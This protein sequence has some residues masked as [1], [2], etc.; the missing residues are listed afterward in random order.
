[1]Q[2]V[3]MI[4]LRDTED[5]DEEYIRSISGSL[6]FRSIIVL[7]LRPG[8]VEDGLWSCCWTNH[9]DSARMLHSFVEDN[10]EVRNLIGLIAL[11]DMLGGLMDD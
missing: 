11:N 2:E 9:E 1:M 4:E 6:G 8:A 5:W 10:P 7:G 3:R